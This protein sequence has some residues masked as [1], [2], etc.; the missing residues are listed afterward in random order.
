MFIVISVS[1][2]DEVELWEAILTLFFFPVLVIL[3]Y[4]ADKKYFNRCGNKGQGA[5]TD[6]DHETV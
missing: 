4:M 5:L 2:P 1:S 6:P 3:A